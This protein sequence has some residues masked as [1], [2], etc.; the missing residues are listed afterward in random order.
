MPRAAVALKKG[1]KRQRSPIPRPLKKKKKKKG[2]T[3]RRDMLDE[4]MLRP[5]R[6]EVQ[7]EIGL[8]DEA[9][10]AQIL[11]IHTGRMAAASFLAADVDLASLAQRTKNFSGAELEG[12]VKS[13][14]SFALNRNVDI[15]DLHKPLDEESIR[16]TAAD[17]EAALA[18]V[19]PAFGAASESLAAYAPHGVIA[20]G[21]AFSHLSDTL[22][23]LVRQVAT[24]D[25]TPLLSVLLEGPPGSG[26]SALAATA[27][28]HSGFP[29]AKVISPEQLVGYGEQA[30][31]S[32]IAKVFDDAY[33]SPLSVVV[34]DDVERLLEY[35]P[36]GPR[37]SNAVLQ[38]L[39]VL[40]KRAPP[41]GRRLLVVATTPSSSAAAAASGADVL[42]GMG[43]ADAFNVV[44]HVPA[45]AAEGAARVLESVGAF[46]VG[47]GAKEAVEVLG[48][49]VGD[50]VPVKKLLL[51][52]EMARQEAIEAA[53]GGSGG[54]SAMADGFGGTSVA[55]GHIP[56]GVWRKVLRD[57]A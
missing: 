48:S 40:V 14:A 16:V 34:L 35:V 22:K 38:T 21:D 37:F 4:A 27:A 20:Y 56:I 13:A 28:L 23:A 30:K 3:N 52:V 18:E 9:G 50:S 5:G 24:S 11:R 32:A 42:G 7:I 41:E 29:F 57:L 15:N 43:L 8:P 12:L 19:Q 6:L 53:G 45:L 49:S 36:V 46:G 39:M 26:K 55:A 31:C 47:V 54:D 1:E 2:M 10:R 51:W 44:L 25:K 17:F 33:K